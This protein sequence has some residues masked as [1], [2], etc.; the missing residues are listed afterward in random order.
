MLVRK[1]IPAPQKPKLKKPKNKVLPNNGAECPLWVKSGHVQCKTACPLYPRKRTWAALFPWRHWRRIGCLSVDCT[2]G[3]GIHFTQNAAR[4]RD[5]FFRSSVGIC[6]LLRG[7]A[8]ASFL[9]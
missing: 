5:L 3:R 4:L 7:H 6:R 9:M 1:T 2:I 8:A